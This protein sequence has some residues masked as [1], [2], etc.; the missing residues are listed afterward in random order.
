MLDFIKLLGFGL[1]ATMV[2]CLALGIGAVVAA[3]GAL[4]G[5]ALLGGAAILVIVLVVKELFDS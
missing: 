3:L 4:L 2:F 1:V 5:T